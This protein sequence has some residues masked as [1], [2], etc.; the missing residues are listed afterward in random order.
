MVTKRKTKRDKGGRV[1]IRSFGGKYAFLSNFHPQPQIEYLD[2][3]WA[4]T[5]YA[6]Q[7]DKSDDPAD[8]DLIAACQ[9]PGEAKKVGQTIKVTADWEKGRKLT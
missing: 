2:R 6:Y 1:V 8:W 7:A 5:E 3:I 4:C 9:T